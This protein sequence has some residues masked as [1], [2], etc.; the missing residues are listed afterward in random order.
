MG[1]D[2]LTRLL[3][4]GRRLVD[5]PAAA[6]AA[7]CGTCLA[8]GRDLGLSGFRPVADRE[9]GQGPAGGIL[10]ALE[11]A[12]TPWV[13]VVAGDMPEVDAALLGAL[14]AEAATDSHSALIP[15]GPHGLEPL[16]A[17]YPRVLADE[18]RTSLEK[19]VDA[20]YLLLSADRR[21]VWPYP[22]VRAVAK[23]SRPFLSLNRPEDW[24]SFTGRLGEEPQPPRA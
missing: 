7:V 20:A 24:E 5:R 10:T 21:R 13:L 19:G 9:P 2:K 14:Q 4:D 18:V 16:V 11:E 8:V 6:L 23:L 12:A 17:A 15:E 3:P 22:A 1:R